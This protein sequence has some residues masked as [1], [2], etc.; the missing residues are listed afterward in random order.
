MKKN[1]AIYTAPVYVSVVMILLGASGKLL[2]MSTGKGNDDL[3]FTAM[4]LELFVYMIPAAFYCKIRGIDMLHS[5]GV[6][7]MSLQ[8]IPFIISAY[9][10]Y[11]LGM[12]FFTYIGATPSGAAEINLTLQSVP[13]TDSFFVILCYI[14]IPAIAEEM[15]FRSVLLREYSSCRG[16]WSILVTSVFFAMLHFSFTAFP[17]YLWGGLILGLITY[18]TNSSLPAVILHML[19]NFAVL[20]FSDYISN[21]LQSAE[22]SIVLIFIISTLFMISL[23]FTVSSLQSIYE[24]KAQEYEDGTLSGSRADAVKSLAKAGRVDKKNKP[25][26]PGT[27]ITLKDIFLSPTMLLAIFVFVFITIGMI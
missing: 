17:A 11:A 9:F 10:L 6:R 8:D 12:L 16:I 15:L 22:N 19:S 23:Y 3:F 21:F 26:V 4:I 18:I 13:D 1:N 20:N 14:V 25:E 5:Y 27:K 7:M 2:E 24:R